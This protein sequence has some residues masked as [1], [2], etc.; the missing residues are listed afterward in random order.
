MPASPGDPADHP[1]SSVNNSDSRYFRLVFRQYGPVIISR[2]RF[3]SDLVSN[4]LMADQ[5]QIFNDEW[6]KKIGATITDTGNALEPDEVKEFGEKINAEALRDYM[7]I[8]GKN[9]RTILE[10]L[11]LEEIKSMVPEEWVMRILEVGGVTTDFRSV[12]LLVFWGRLTRAGMILTPMTY[13][14]MMHLPAC[15]DHLSIID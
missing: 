12:W 7:I 11:T 2:L 3:C 8:V 4:I 5:D 1:V 15:I 14:H 13:H 10:K 9:T 6:Q